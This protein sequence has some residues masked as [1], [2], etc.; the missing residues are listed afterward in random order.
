MDSEAEQ[1]DIVGFW[2]KVAA[3]VR[4]LG[5][6]EEQLFLILTLFIG[7]VVGLA[8]VAFIV[9]TEN[10][11]SQ[12][13]P[14]AGA[15]WRRVVV[16]VVGALITGYLLYRFAPDA[17]GSGV[18]QTKAALF[19]RA[20]RITINTVIGKF[21]FTAGALASGIPLGREGPSVQVGAGIASV[22]GRR[23]GL[24]QDRAKA[25]VPAG[26][27]AALAAA[28][29]TPLAAVL[30]TLE[31]L[32]GDMHAPVLG[33][34]VLSAATSWLVLRMVLGDEPLFHVPHYDL[35]HP[36]EFIF[37]AL[38]GLLGGLVSVVFVKLLLRLRA[39]FLRLPARGQWFYP[40]AGG[41]SVGL[42][43]LFVPEV[44]GVGYKFVSQALNGG[45]LLR[46][47]VILVVFKLLT[48]VI[49]YAS[50]NA[51]GIFG[52]SLYIGAML[53]GAV[54][55][56]AHTVL[57]GYT[58]TPG[59]YALVG[60]GAAFAG[61]IRAPMTSV[62]MIF[63]ITRDYSI[64]VPLMIANTISLFISARLQPLPIYEELSLQDGIHL[65]TSKTLGR[66]TSPLV[67]RA[68]RPATEILSAQM[69]VSEALERV[70]KS[71]SHAWP[72]M[73]KGKFVGMMA[74][75]ILE[76]AAEQGQTAQPLSAL[77]PSGSFPHVHS[78]QPLEQALGRMG[79]A[80]LDVLP[81]VS[82]ANVHELQGVVTLPEVLHIYGIQ[83]I[84][85][86]S[87]REEV[88]ESSNPGSEPG[89]RT[90]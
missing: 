32:M 42:L 89:P 87:D 40:V 29:N 47:M 43:G 60:M 53:G 39:W 88:G 27:S 7:G 55:Y 70:R 58:G 19:A 79:K 85:P 17:R 73:D 64:I 4:R 50:G 36:V 8:V 21:L 56:V 28:F 62:V 67:E 23:L 78:D 65:P 69:T 80:G 22:I 37:Y 76:E 33:S 68:L 81:V 48:V 90:S 54:G 71:T 9:L 52:P 66:S 82:R 41:L 20:G 51:G 86:S 12:M 35:V 38:L 57:P 3:G 24:S 1:S 34:V 31:E 2:D 44:L 77:L 10:L 63:E 25:L 18:P 59:A 49:S 46:L 84:G 26:V 6:A 72:V 5:L 16:P 61:I 45:M 15:P 11:G 13:Y 83:P 14:P 30:F 74:A 75:H